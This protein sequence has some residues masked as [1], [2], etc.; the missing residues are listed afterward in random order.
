MNAIPRTIEATTALERALGQIDCPPARKV[1][2]MSKWERGEL[3][4][5]AAMY[6]IRKL[7]LVSA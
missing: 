4:A 5:S 6:L 3:S 2:I 1:V 7:D